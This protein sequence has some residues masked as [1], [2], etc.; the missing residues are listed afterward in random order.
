MTEPLHVVVV[1]D[2]AY[3]AG[4]ASKVALESAKG[5]A[6]RGHE[7]TVMAAMGP[8]SD[9]LALA[10]VRAEV[11]GQKD[12][13]TGARGA[14]AIQ[15]L[16]NTQ[17]EREL[18]QLLANRP[19]GRTIVHVHSWSKALSPSVF[20]AAGRAGHPVIATLHDYG[21]ACPNAALHIFPT[22]RPCTLEPMSVPCLTT[23]CDS[24]RYHH[25]LWRIARQVSLEHVA[26]AAHRL[27]TAICV[28]A[29]SHDILRPLLPRSLRTTVVDN[30]IEAVNEGPADPAANRGF[31]YV[32]RF[33]AEKGV[34]LLAQATAEA[35]LPIVFV[36]E[37]E[38]EADIR[39][40][41]PA[42][43]L[44]GWLP[45]DQVR[46]RM[47][48][49][50]AVVMPSTWRETQGMVV[51]EAFAA[52]LPVITSSDTAPGAATQDGVTGL[53]FRNGDVED[54]K[55]ALTT[56]ASDDTLVRQMG[57]AAYDQFWAAPP[58]L[59]RHV[60]GLEAVYRRALARL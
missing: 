46:A 25:K 48:A 28:S 42:A 53:V 8:P 13:A 10:G 6:A 50:R 14:V 33:S 55:R 22:G 60:D 27:D 18:T 15:G 32:G 24:R 7:V 29:Y 30:P 2:R 44:T 38:L 12:L 35:N 37:G 56:L 23:N 40:I 43:V 5:L 52:G 54:L 34:L 57:Q 21:L 39:R 16:W 4:G 17:S 41:N 31:V 3:P 26:R 20:A 49:G 45:G 9:D 59:D 51:P 19:A 1:N 11:L 36:G 58:S 47:R